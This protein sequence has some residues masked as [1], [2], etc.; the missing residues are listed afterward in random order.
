MGY[1]DTWYKYK[2]LKNYTGKN[3]SIYLLDSGVD[4][5]HEEFSNANIV[6][7]FSYDD[8]FDDVT[9]HG[10][11]VASVIVGKTL[12]IA[13]NVTLKIVKIAIDSDMTIGKKLEAFNAILSDKPTDAVGIVLCAWTILKNPIFD[14][15]ILELQESNFLVVSAAGNDMQPTSKFSPIGL[16][17]TIGVG[18]VDINGKAISW[19]NCRGNNYGDDVKVFA[20]GINVTIA[21]KDNQYTEVSGSSIAAAIV[22]GILAQYVEQYPQKTAQEIEKL[23]LANYE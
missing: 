22:A 5:T 7:V 17:T 8:T 6:N 9:G 18:A 13:P 11:G 21:T 16:G 2:L 4:R 1:I 15:K 3:V 12:G 14:Q 23:F 20:P 10:T 19:A